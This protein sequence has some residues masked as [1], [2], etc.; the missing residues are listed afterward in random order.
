MAE[1]D[2]PSIGV[3]GDRYL[4]EGGTGFAAHGSESVESTKFDYAGHYG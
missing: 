3:V 2:R 4:K 1:I